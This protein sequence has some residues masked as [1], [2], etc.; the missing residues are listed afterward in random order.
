MHGTLAWQRSRSQASKGLIARVN[1]RSMCISFKRFSQSIVGFIANEVGSEA[2]V[3]KAG[4]TMLEENTKNK[5][6]SD[7]E[8]VIR[9]AVA[10]T[11]HSDPLINRAKNASQL[12]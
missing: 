5:M 7:Q 3:I 2:A 10:L 4:K 8:Q 12:Y 6:F 1:G 9:P 11:P